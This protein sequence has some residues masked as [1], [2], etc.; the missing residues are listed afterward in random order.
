MAE[1]NVRSGVEAAASEPPDIPGYRLLRRIGRGSYGEVWLAQSPEG[2]YRAV[3]VVYR[4]TFERERPFEREFSGIQRF[5]P[6]SRAHP[7]QVSIL[8][9]GRND[10]AGFFYY[11]MEL[12]DDE[13]SGQE[14]DPAN[15]KP[16][17]LRSEV[18]RAGRI[19]FDRA[20]DISLSLTKALEHLHQH[21][22][23]HRDI[24]P[25]NII[26]VNGVP[27]LADIGLVT[28]V[29]A[30]ISY[31]GTE[32]F[33][34]PEGPVSQQADIYSLG[35]VLYEMSTGQDR[36]EF[37]E[38]PT[39]LGETEEKAGLLELNLVF[40]KA[41]QN[42]SQKRYRTAQEMYADLVVLRSGK[43]LKRARALEKRLQT[44]TRAFVATTV[45]GLIAAGGYYAWH[46]HQVNQLKIEVAAGERARQAV[47]KFASAATRRLGNLCAATGERLATEND[48]SGALA[49]FAA[50]LQAEKEPAQAANHEGRLLRVIERLPR[51]VGFVSH[52]AALNSA[53]FSRD[54]TQVVT[55][56]DDQ[57]VKIW[58]LNPGELAGKPL[59]H[60]SPVLY[61]ELS[62]EQDRLV[63]ICKDGS[64]WL[65]QLS[66]DTSIALELG[67]G[68]AVRAAEFSPNGRFALTRGENRRVM[69]WDAL[70]T[71]DRFK[72]EH[73]AVPAEAHY[74][75]DGKC[76]AVIAGDRLYVWDTERGE[77]V[78]EVV[79]P[80]GQLTRL[81]LSGDSRRLLVV[82]GP[83]AQVCSVGKG[84]WSSFTLSEPAPITSAAF[85]PD[86]RV[87]TGTE[88]GSVRVWDAVSGK[89]S[90]NWRFRGVIHALAISPDAAAVVCASDHQAWVID[91]KTGETR[92]PPAS[93]R[94]ALRAAA[95]SSDARLLL[96]A[97]GD[98]G[99]WISEMAAR[100]SNPISTKLSREE[101]VAFTRLLA[102]RQ[103]NDDEQLVEVESE[104]LL[105][106][107][108]RL[109]TSSALAPLTPVA[110]HL[111]RAERL[112]NDGFW[113]GVRFH[114]DRLSKLGALDAR[115]R[116]WDAKAAQEL[117]R[118]QTPARKAGP[119]PERSPDAPPNLVDLTRF[120]NAGLNET[121]F[122]S[123]YVGRA[124]DLSQIP[125][126]VQKFNGVLFDV[127]G[128]IQLSGTALENLGGKFPDKVTGIPVQRKARKLHFMQGASWEALYGTTIGKY[129]INY[130][131]GERRE[132]KLVFGKNVRDWWFPP[133]QPQTT[134]EA[135]VAWQGNNPA[136][137]Q[138]GMAIR[139]YQ[140]GWNNPLPDEVIDSI[141]FISMME[142]PA[143][144]LLAI[145]TES[146]D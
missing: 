96:T 117:D 81:V 69:V 30:S 120:Y 67:H 108:R 104:N 75:P 130:A 144:F 4:A 136:S 127:R 70:S 50:A 100:S 138:M 13:V 49:W 33:L 47:E 60:Q 128:V 25:S 62:P 45:I 24:K 32:G 131:N 51:L 80:N 78:V 73:E 40:L 15:Y 102:G 106:D 42:D 38:L 94:N 2:S 21:D 20:L 111:A 37:P 3:K 88:D 39:F 10:E 29:G 124:N 5:E 65:W 133:T 26:F 98:G 14:I 76:I 92:V 66:R 125:S 141:D 112:Y 59:R 23:I 48:L 11:V 90:G 123:N 83:I 84:E 58:N 22:L 28:D 12:A 116:G 89:S 36:L 34:P 113:L 41:C 27:K 17:T 114:A 72:L 95:L 145:T 143:P 56:G 126:G 115:V 9:V 134:T 91:L 139:I 19:P 64:A 43:S 132:V 74:S 137:Q 46:R 121:W 99:V 53:G 7:S 63:S 87:V 101:I 68:A 35:K 82:A 129:Q 55:A 54:A 110:W 79:S 135:A 61:A 1:L 86:G 16:K 119:I 140:M 8:Q 118:Y 57:T 146:A 44:L 142:K 107:W 71:R 31:V 105:T 6:V 93:Y 122:P 103:V 85:T 109:Q 97:G 77:K 18:A 52:G